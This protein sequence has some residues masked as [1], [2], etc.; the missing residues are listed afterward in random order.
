MGILEFPKAEPE[1]RGST[2]PLKWVGNKVAKREVIGD[3]LR[4]NMVDLKLL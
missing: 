4:K 2:V 1:V 3:T